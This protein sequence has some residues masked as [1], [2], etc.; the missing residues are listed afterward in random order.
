MSIVSSMSSQFFQFRVVG[1]ETWTIP[2]PVVENSDSINITSN[3]SNMNVQGS[4]EGMSAFNYVNNPTIPL[5]IKFHEDLWREYNP[6][7]TYEET[8]AKLASLQY[9]GGTSTIEPPY[10]ILSW[11]GYTFRGFI[12]SVRITQSGPMRNGHR[13]FCEVGL[14]FTVVKSTSPS[15]SEIASSFKTTFQ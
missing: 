8:I 13:V 2:A 5:T 4:T 7:H 11:S 3:W 1:E 15:R 14:Q 6:G 12:T 9:P 10:V